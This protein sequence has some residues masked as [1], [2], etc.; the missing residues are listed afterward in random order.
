M[1][2]HLTHF[3]HIQM[4]LMWIYYVYLCKLNCNT[5]KACHGSH[6]IH[7]ITH[8]I[9]MLLHAV[10][11]IA[12]EFTE[13]KK[14]RL[15]FDCLSASTVRRICTLFLSNSMRSK[16]AGNRSITR[17]LNRLSTLCTG[18]SIFNGFR[19]WSWRI[20]VFMPCHEVHVVKDSGS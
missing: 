12:D 7:S 1:F 5:N 18:M 6:S 13:R 17:Y 15:P 16:H 2:Q 19:S 14:Q 3:P 9:K 11:R 10:C 8:T 4:Q 20:D